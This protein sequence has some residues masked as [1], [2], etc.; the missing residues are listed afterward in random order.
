MQ[1]HVGRHISPPEET[2][3]PDGGTPVPPADISPPQDPRLGTN[4]WRRRAPV[5]TA[6]GRCDA[7][8]FAWVCPGWVERA[9]LTC[10]SWCPVPG[11]PSAV[12]R[13]GEMVTPDQQPTDQPAAVHSPEVPPVQ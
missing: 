4:V 7:T 6:V 13:G 12:P 2:N 9:R 5:V 11:S 10:G 3:R 8:G 1:I